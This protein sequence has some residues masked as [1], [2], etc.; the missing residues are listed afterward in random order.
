MHR[1]QTHVLG[2]SAGATLALLLAPEAT[3]AQDQWQQHAM[4]RPRPEVVTPQEQNLPAP[5]PADAVVLFDGTDLS[6]WQSVNGGP[7]EEMR[8]APQILTQQL[9]ICAV[10]SRILNGR[11]SSPSLVGTR[12][13]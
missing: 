7:A 3:R 8:S 12:P 5:A 1:F 10:S 11:C 9:S 2:A 6:A 4:D 13:M